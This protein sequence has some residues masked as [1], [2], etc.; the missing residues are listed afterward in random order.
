MRKNKKK[1]QT[2]LKS[3]AENAVGFLTKSPP[4]TFLQ[5]LAFSNQVL[6]KSKAFLQHVD[7]IKIKG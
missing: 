7:E 6:T 2:M 5:E 3:R 4:K 1:L